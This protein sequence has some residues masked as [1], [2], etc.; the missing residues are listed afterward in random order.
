LEPSI[1]VASQFVNEGNKQRVLKHILAWSRARGA[2]TIA[3]AT[4]ESAKAKATAVPVPEAS[5]ATETV[6]DSRDDDA[7]WM[8]SEVFLSLASEAQVLEVGLRYIV[9]DM[10]FAPYCVIASKQLPHR[11][12]IT[13]Q[14]LRN[15]CAFASKSPHNRSEITPQ[16]PRNHFGTT[17]RSLRKHCI[18]AAQSFLNYCAIAL[19]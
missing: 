3:T 18:I 17:L 4:A 16:S 5:K 6:V 1:A 15:R 12:E 7:D 13:A 10:L 2:E 9:S 8:A 14:S 11:G 19:R